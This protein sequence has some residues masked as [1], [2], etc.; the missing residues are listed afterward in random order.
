MDPTAPRRTLRIPLRHPLMAVAGAAAALTALGIL[1]ASA[2]QWLR[3]RR[4]L[5]NAR[6]APDGF[7][8]FESRPNNPRARVL[9][10]GDSTAVGL[11]ADDPRDSLAGMLGAS[12][13]QVAITNRAVSGSRLQDVRAQ[14][15]ALSPQEREEGG[16][17]LILLFV[18]GNDVL[19]LTPM[20][21]LQVEAQALLPDLRK[22]AGKL[23]WISSGNIG[24]APLLVPPW[25]WWATARA[26][27]VWQLF[28]AV[29][30]RHDA[31][32]VS[33]FHERGE[34]VFS[35]EPK[36]YFAADGMHPT[37][38]AYRICYERLRE[39]VCLDLLLE[40]AQA[41]HASAHALKRA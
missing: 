26:R 2:T 15:E 27:R 40:E 11:G 7:K 20:A 38:A 19:R 30:Q 31:V 21:R 18:G 25:S 5:Q 12:H 4:A 6:L 32:F 3:L 29:S 13:P 16:Y 36:L 22:L 14:I 10:L 8:P 37:G 41:R 33:F 28:D 17:D 35:R 24:L 34:D 9:V 23:V 39:L 1:S